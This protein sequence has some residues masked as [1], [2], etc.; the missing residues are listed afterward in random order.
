MRTVTM[1]SKKHRTENRRGFTAIELLIAIGL[2]AA[3]AGITIPMYRQFQ[4][5]SDLDTATEHLVQAVRAAQTLSQ[6]GKFDS[7]WGVYFPDGTLYAGQDYASRNSEKDV[8]FPLPGSIE[9]DGLTEVSF[10]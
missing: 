3:T 7:R 10:T 5:Y 6:T 4:V 1:R 8:S 9:T 2:M